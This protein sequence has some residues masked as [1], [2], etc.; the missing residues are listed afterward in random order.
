MDQVVVVRH[1]GNV[2]EFINDMKS[3]ISKSKP[4]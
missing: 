1:K 4:K 3:F 2:D